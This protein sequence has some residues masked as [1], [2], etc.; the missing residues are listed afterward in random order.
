MNSEQFPYIG[1]VVLGHDV[2]K[3]TLFENWEEVEVWTG[4]VNDWA[5]NEKVDTVI[6]ILDFDPDDMTHSVF[7]ETD[8]EQHEGY[9]FSTMKRV[10]K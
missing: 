10:K 9:R 1:Y 5:F 3:F 4:Q 6:T 7:I 8:V 2:N